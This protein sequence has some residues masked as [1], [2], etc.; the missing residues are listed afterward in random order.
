VK[1]IVVMKQVPDS[2]AKIKVKG[3]GSGIETDGI[4]YVM[5]PYDEYAVEEALRLK[6]KVGEGSTVT[7][8]SVGPDRAVEAI[9]TALAMGADDAVPSISTMR[10]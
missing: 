9:R 8:V 3:D 7:V 1:I 6:E 5:S 2:E 10:S 4:K